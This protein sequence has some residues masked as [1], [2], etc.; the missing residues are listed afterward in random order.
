[1]QS[2][3]EHFGGK[4]DALFEHA[5]RLRLVGVNRPYKVKTRQI[6]H[7]QVAHLPFEN[8]KLPD[9]QLAQLWHKVDVRAPAYRM[10]H[11]MPAMEVRTGRKRVTRHAASVSPVFRENR[12]AIGHNRP[13][14]I[15][16]EE[17]SERS[18]RFIQIDRN[19]IRPGILETVVIAPERD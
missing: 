12:H 7:C 11:Q 14:Q 6:L 16:I 5:G 9:V 3:G 17:V 13:L 18:A 1:M 19:Q 8:P 4:N 10:S 2:V 15:D